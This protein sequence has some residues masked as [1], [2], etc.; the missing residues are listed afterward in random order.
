MGKGGGGGGGCNVKHK[1]NE[2]TFSLGA[3]SR[4][5]WVEIHRDQ[6]PDLI[7]KAYGV[8]T[9]QKPDLT[10]KVHW[11]HFGQKPDSTPKVHGVHTG[12]IRFDS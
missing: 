12:Q 6:K 7:P 11:L 10:P 8:H 2:A 5:L 9:G 4:L 1:T 3:T